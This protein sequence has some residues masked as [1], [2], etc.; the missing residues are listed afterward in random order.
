MFV[1]TIDGHRKRHHTDSKWLPL[2]K[3]TQRN[4][5]LFLSATD[6][7][8]WLPIVFFLPSLFPFIHAARRGSPLPP[9]QYWECFFPFF[10]ELL[11][12]LM[13]YC[14][15]K[16]SALN[17][18]EPVTTQPVYTPL[19]AKLMIWVATEALSGHKKA[20]FGYEDEELFFLVFLSLLFLTSYALFNV[21]GLVFE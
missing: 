15:A 8:N 13:L 19:P 1:I 5:S 11:L 17:Y 7:L 14:S 6:W 20:L 12:L 16:H 9:S 4:W 18:S 3:R 2:T 10:E 21:K